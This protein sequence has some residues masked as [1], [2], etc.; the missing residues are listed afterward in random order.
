MSKVFGDVFTI[1]VVYVLFLI[2][3]LIP[4]YANSD[5]KIDTYVKVNINDFQK[6]VRKN[7]YI[8]LKTYNDFTS[9]LSRTGKIYDIYLIHKSRLVYPKGNGD[10][11]VE[12]IAYS[13]YQ[14][15]NKINNDEKYT[16]KNGD[17]FKVIVQERIPGTSK[18]LM[19]LL[20]MTLP[21]KNLFSNGGMVENEIFN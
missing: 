21:E 12:K 7:G 20:T 15:F 19:G 5:N 4:S 17:D 9:Q 11:S 2:G 14:I 16:M 18:F 1:V 10:F 6:E 3:V 8:D 13:N